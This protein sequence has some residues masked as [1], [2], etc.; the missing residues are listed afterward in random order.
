MKNSEFLQS[1]TEW[2]KKFEK[3][4]KFQVEKLTG[5]YRKNY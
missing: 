3:T 2:F 1:L 5:W 4:T